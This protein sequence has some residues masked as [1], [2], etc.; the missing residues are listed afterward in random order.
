MLRLDLDGRPV[1]IATGDRPF[2]PAL[3]CCVLVHGAQNDSFVWAQVARGLAGP[4]LAV[5]APDLPGHGQSG[6]T[7]LPSIERMAD[8][9]VTLLEK[10]GAGTTA[11]LILA[12]HSMGSLIALEVAARLPQRVRRL[13]MVG[14]AVPMPVAPPL[15]DAARD[16]PADAMAMINRWSHSPLAARGAR[17]GHG[18]WL[19]NLALRLMERQPAATLRNDLSACNAY[20]GGMD[21]AACLACPVTLV[22]G[23]ADRMTP[24]KAARAWAAALRAAAPTVAIERVELP[25]VG[26]ALPT[27]APAAVISVLRHAAR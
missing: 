24:L 15:L 4:S 18:L 6:G 5:L 1:G 8:W 11:P 13:V 20:A 22:A 21:A 17:G 14:T 2:D 7:P 3:P 23:T 27:E 19:P 10:I 16:A 9:L 25:G 26:H 12:G